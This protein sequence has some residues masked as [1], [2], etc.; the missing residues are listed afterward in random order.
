MVY[1]LLF[2]IIQNRFQLF[3]CLFVCLAFTI[4]IYLLFR[5]DLLPND[6]F[7]DKLDDSKFFIYLF[8]ICIIV[9]VLHMSL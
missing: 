2:Y 9:V 8:L 4:C 1:E 7:V 6:I 5:S 3:V